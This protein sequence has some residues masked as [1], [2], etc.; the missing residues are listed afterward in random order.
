[1][2][3]RRIGW[4]VRRRALETFPRGA[5]PIRIAATKI[6]EP[7]LR[8]PLEILEGALRREFPDHT[9]LR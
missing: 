6:G 8:F 2:T 5:L 4:R 1:V 3:E 9:F 7:A